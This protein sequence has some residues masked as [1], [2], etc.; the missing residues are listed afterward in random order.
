MSDGGWDRDPLVTL[1]ALLALRYEQGNWQAWR[2]QT[3][4][5]TQALRALRQE[6]AREL[7]REMWMH[8]DR[9]ARTP[10][11]GQ[12]NTTVPG[13]LT[14][15]SD[16]LVA[17][18]VFLPSWLY[19]GAARTTT[20]HLLR[21]LDDPAAQEQRNLLLLALAWVDADLVHT[22]FH[23]WRT[24][25]PAWRVDVYRAPEEFATDAGWELTP[26]GSRRQLYRS[27][28]YELVPVDEPEYT[29]SARA[30]AVSTP[31]E[32]LCG[33]CG[34]RLV[35]LLDIDLSDPRCV[36]V[37]G[38]EVEEAHGATRLRIAH[39]LWCSTY[40]TLYTDIDLV[41]SSVWSAANDDKPRILDQVGTGAGEGMAEPALRRLAIGTLR[42]TPFEAVGRFQLDETGISQ[43]GGHPEWIQDSAYPICPSCQR[44]MECIGQVS[45]EDQ[46][47]FAE[48]S[49]YAFLCLPC[50]KAA[51]TYQQT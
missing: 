10:F 18:Q 23:A 35:T 7:A 8:P 30:V 34:R 28:C 27:T 20:Q 14:D 49:T 17:Q 42:R 21:L 12:L 32:A 36:F 5:L 26:G 41:G 51:T 9:E 1:R 16:E 22:R 37:V 45:W 6:Q 43:F 11:L 47:A 19:L 33:W 31:H 50:G 13:A 2:Q 46:D 38:E 29:P 39:C 15:V 24:N 40:A 44:R 3:P 48:G 25:L 4:Q